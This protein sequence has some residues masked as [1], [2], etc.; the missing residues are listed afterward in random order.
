VT[1]KTWLDMAKQDAERRGLA[2]LRPL[3]EGLARQTASLRVADW[4]PDPRG[5][6]YPS[7]TPDAR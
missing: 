4:N 2:T 3:L 6:F 1:T 7:T 5:E